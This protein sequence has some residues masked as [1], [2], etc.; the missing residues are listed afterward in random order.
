MSRPDSLRTNR[1]RAWSRALGTRPEN[2][3]FRRVP[4][5]C[6]TDA[7]CKD[8]GQCQL[9]QWNNGCGLEMFA[10]TSSKDTCKTTKDCNGT[11][12][13]ECGYAE[14]QHRFMCMTENCAF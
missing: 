9:A 14:D 2:R 3:P 5:L 1:V 13:A 11:A 4:A 10:C 6:K 7:D 12:R 8:G